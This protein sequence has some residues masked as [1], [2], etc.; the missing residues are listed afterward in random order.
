MLSRGCFDL[1]VIINDKKLTIF[2][3]KTYY[4]VQVNM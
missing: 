2:Q 1:V 4:S 3:N